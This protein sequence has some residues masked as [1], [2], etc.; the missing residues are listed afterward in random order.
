MALATGQRE[1]AEQR[2]S[3]DRQRR[4]GHGHRRTTPDNT[5][6]VRPLRD[7]SG[8]RHFERLGREEI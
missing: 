8:Q 4:T 3:P 6:H 1:A 7:V 2:G 5:F